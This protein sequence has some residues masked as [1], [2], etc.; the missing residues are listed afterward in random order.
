MGDFSSYDNKLRRNDETLLCRMVAAG[1]VLFLNSGIRSNHLRSSCAIRAAVSLTA[2]CAEPSCTFLV[3]STRL[4]RQT[5]K[6]A[7]SK[8]NSIVVLD[9]WSDSTIVQ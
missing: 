5:S 8:D 6:S 3:F 1:L 4:C 2:N 7:C 9:S